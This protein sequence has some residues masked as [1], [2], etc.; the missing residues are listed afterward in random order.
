MMAAKCRNVKPAA[1]NASR[2]V[3]LDT[4]RA[5]MR[6]WTDAPWHRRVDG[7][8]RPGRGRWPAPPVS[9]APRSRVE[10]Q[11]RGDRR[12]DREYRCEQPALAAGGDPRHQYA[13]RV[14][15]SDVGAER[16]P[17]PG[18]RPEIRPPAPVRT[19]RR[20]PR[21]QETAPVAITV[22][23]P[24]TATGPASG[25]AATRNPECGQGGDG[26][27]QRHGSVG[28]HSVGRCS[29]TPSAAASA[30]R[31]ASRR[32][33]RHRRTAVPAAGG[34]AAGRSHPSGSAPPGAP[35][36]R[37]VSA[38]SRAG[39]APVAGRAGRCPDRPPRRA[40]RPTRRNETGAATIKHPAPSGT[41]RHHRR[42]G[43]TAPVHRGLHGWFDRRFDHAGIPVRRAVIADDQGDVE[44]AGGASIPP[45]WPPRRG[46]RAAR[47]RYAPPNHRRPASPPSAA[48]PP[49]SPWR[50]RSGCAPG[51]PH[52]GCAPPDG[53]GN[54]RCA[55]ARARS[56]PARPAAVTVCWKA[57]GKHRR[58]SIGY[59]Q[60]GDTGPGDR[61]RRGRVRRR[62]VEVPRVVIDIG[63]GRLSGACPRA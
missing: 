14:E 18:W 46:R 60:C 54:R 9:A 30:V 62:Q 13:R 23:A 61:R 16:A 27:D 22:A 29:S 21:V 50:G 63:P 31:A 36:V 20:P 59:Q 33:D 12:R 49:P 42:P 47:A 56:G 57:V 37:T 43:L 5:T 44:V 15:Q 4:G 7:P 2:L 6:C 58:H 8:A 17:A 52:R 28:C 11:H 19:P 41:V 45:G 38:S 35:T 55:A 24:T 53:R 40:D 25:G 51:A 34:P 26:E 1:L 48:P 32:P 3:R 10:A 39:S